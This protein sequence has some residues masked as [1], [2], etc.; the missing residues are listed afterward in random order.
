MTLATVNA[1]SSRRIEAPSTGDQGV[2]RGAQRTRSPGAG[3][4]LVAALAV[5][6]QR[7]VEGGRLDR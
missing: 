5:D 2:R 4:Q 1:S 3:E 6:Q 7:A